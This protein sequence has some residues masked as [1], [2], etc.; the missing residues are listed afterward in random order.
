MEPMTFRVVEAREI[1]A[2][3]GI[4]PIHWILLTTW[5]CSTFDLAKRVVK[6]YSKRW[7]IEEFHKA[8]KT[9]V[10]AEKT[11]LSTS[12]RILALF[13]VL[14]VVAARIVQM[15]LL[16]AS[17]PDEQVDPGTLT[18]EAFAV[19]EANQPVPKGGWT[20][21]TLL[22]AVARL[23]GFLGRRSDGDPGWITLWRGWQRLMDLVQGYE[24]AMQEK[25]TRSG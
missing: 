10:G 1:G 16:A 3:K 20:N 7:L 21:R 14:A 2:P 5:D 25:R 4:E 24:L 18:P 8:L 22:I 23:G 6:S 11:Q 9:G 13:G 19:L 12:R 15:K 17:C